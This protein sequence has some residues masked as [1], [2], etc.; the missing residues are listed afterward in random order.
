MFPYIGTSTRRDTAPGSI[1]RAPVSE[2]TM[3]LLGDGDPEKLQ[4]CVDAFHEHWDEL[5][6]R[7]KKTGTHLPPHGIAPYYFYYAH[8]YA[9]LAIRMLPKEAQDAE[10]KKFTKVLMKT[11]DDDNTWND[12]VFEQSKAYGTSM[13]LL[14]LCR[15]SVALPKPMKVQVEAKESEKSD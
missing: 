15:D 7:R 9:A 10:F 13:S 11:Q 8:R 3:M 6:K 5:E 2:A 1:A 14:A 12:R 4:Q